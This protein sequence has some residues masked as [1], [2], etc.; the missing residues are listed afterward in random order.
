VFQSGE[1]SLGGVDVAC[2]QNKIQEKLSVAASSD[3][4][5]V[6]NVVKCRQRA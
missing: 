4:V 6:T 1:E 2:K 3:H 5:G